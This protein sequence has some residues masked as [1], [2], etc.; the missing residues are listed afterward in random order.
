MHF[1]YQQVSNIPY[2]LHQAQ[3]AATYVS[4]CMLESLTSGFPLSLWQGK[5]S[6]HSRCMR[7]PQSYVSGKSLCSKTNA[8]K[9]IRFEESSTKWL[10]MSITLASL[11]KTWLIWEIWVLVLLLLLLVLLGLPFD[12]LLVTP[13][14][15]YGMSRQHEQYSFIEYHTAVIPPTERSTYLRFYHFN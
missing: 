7:N 8:L 1:E 15:K 11:N 6:R 5:R 12:K 2:Y 3:I 13:W 10:Q 4:W 14:Y 9:F